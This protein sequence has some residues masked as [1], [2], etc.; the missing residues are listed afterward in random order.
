[1]TDQP[2]VSI[3]L[4]VYNAANYIEQAIRSVFGQ[5]TKKWEL[6]IINDGSTDESKHIIS[7]FVDHRIKYYEQTNQGVSAARNI[8]LVHMSGE[9]FCFLDADDVLP[10]HS[11]SSRLGIFQKDPKVTF[12]DGTV[13]LID[14]NGEFLTN[15]YQPTFRGQPLG[16]L[17]D[18]KDSCFF[19]PSWMIKRKPGITYHFNEQMTHSEDLVFYISLAKDGWYDYTED[20]VLHYRRHQQSAMS[21]LMGLEQGYL[22]L[23]QFVKQ[24]YP[25]R[26]IT[27][28]K[29]KAAKIMFLSHSFDG[30][31][32]LAAF[33]SIFRFLNS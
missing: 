17:I 23:I 26:N 32:L 27:F 11:L 15:A 22:D 10:P 6:L 3:I 18:L 2:Q 14:Q 30:K 19:G 13:Q 16:E 8:G 9:Y 7:S 4:P 12:V 31:N 28:T 21:N 20:C 1:M 24:N 33:R 25:E 5:D 29:F